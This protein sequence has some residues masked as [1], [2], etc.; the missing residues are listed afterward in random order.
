MLFLQQSCCQRR[1][2]SS[3]VLL[4][5]PVILSARLME[6]L[7]GDSCSQNGALCKESLVVGYFK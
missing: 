5:F 2:D 7:R 6:L 4:V 3:Y 1:F